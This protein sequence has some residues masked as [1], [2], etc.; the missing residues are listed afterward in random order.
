MSQPK[1]NNFLP[2]YFTVLGVGAA[3]L[4][5]LAFSAGGAAS[6]AAATY[7]TTKANHERLNAA[8]LFPSAENLDKKTEIVNGFVEKVEALNDSLRTYQPALIEIGNSEFQTKLQSSRDALMAATKGVMT[9]PADFDLGMKDYLEKAP[10]EGAASKLSTQVDALN[11]LVTSAMEAGV[12]KIDSLKREVMPFEKD[13]NAPA[14][15][16]KPK[17]K[18]APAPKAPARTPAR[19]TAAP[20]EAVVTLAEREVLERYPIQLTISG[21][22]QAIIDFIGR[23]AN[24]SPDNQTPFFFVPN[25]VRIENEKKQGPSKSMVVGVDKVKD[26]ASAD[27][28]AEYTVDAEFI[29]GGEEVRAFL[30]IDMVRFL[31]APEPA[32]A[33]GAAKAP[34]KTTPAAK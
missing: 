13:P 27:G 18:P 7:A 33:A 22:N 6:E 16:G 20:K 24:T 25:L 34:A 17:P 3:A 5:Y 31:D 15:G 26:P 4:G 23:I 9:L 32:P 8:G 28:K 19:G 21:K 14:A 12:R 1:K 30:Q 2:I 29:F 10:I 11:F